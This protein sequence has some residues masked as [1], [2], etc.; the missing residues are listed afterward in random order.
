MRHIIVLLDSEGSNNQYY[1]GIKQEPGYG[2]VV[3][4]SDHQAYLI[5]TEELAEVRR[6]IE[7]VAPHLC[8]VVHDTIPIL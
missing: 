6:S 8:Y 7:A 5:K 2:T 4:G 1:N 3:L